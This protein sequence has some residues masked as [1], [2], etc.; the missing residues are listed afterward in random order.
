MEIT[1]D[2]LL[3]KLDDIRKI[4][5][6]SEKPDWELVSHDICIY[7][8]V[9]DEFF[10]YKEYYPLLDGE[11]RK[12]IADTNIDI[13]LSNEN[14]RDKLKE[15]E[16][17]IY[18]DEFEYYQFDSEMIDGEIIVPDLNSN[19]F[20]GNVTLS[21]ELV[22]ND[23]STETHKF[24]FEKE[25]S[26]SDI[27]LGDVPH[28]NKSGVTDVVV[29]FEIENFSKLLYP[30]N[31]SVKSINDKECD[32]N[33]ERKTYNVYDR[34]VVSFEPDGFERDYTVNNTCWNNNARRWPK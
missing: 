30:E 23:D 20:A 16:I 14:V 26:Y 18:S 19:M 29:S 32:L 22:Y 10:L 15:L 17:K 7:T 4:I 8:L 13:H 5:I 34:I 11:T 21:L 9:P 24:N 1:K 2:K 31:I 28:I 3:E 27:V 25:D 33:G 6:D 12:V